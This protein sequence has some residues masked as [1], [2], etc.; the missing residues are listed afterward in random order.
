MALSFERHK[1]LKVEKTMQPM[2]FVDLQ[3][4]KENRHKLGV[5]LTAY[6]GQ[7]LYWLANKQ[8]YNKLKNA[9]NDMQEQ[10]DKEFT[11]LLQ[12]AK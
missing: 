3:Q 9:F 10:G 8:D 7:S 11:H 5:A 12:T 1:N 4:E 6:Y 2:L